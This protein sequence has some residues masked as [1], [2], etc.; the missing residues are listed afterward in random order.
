MATERMSALASSGSETSSEPSTPPSPRS[1]TTSPSDTAGER[2]SAPRPGW[3]RALHRVAASLTLKLVALI[4]IF[5]A[6]PVVLYGQFESADR[7][8]RDLV[9]RALQDRSALIADA[10]AP[11]LK[12]IDPSK[13]QVALNADLAKYSSDGTILKL[14][15]QPAGE[16]DAAGVARRVFFLAAAPPIPAPEV[17]AALARLS[18]PPLLPRPSHRCPLG[19]T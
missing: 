10:L 13:G 7:Q 5:A 1:I 3:R 6:L 4:G 16:H 8:M 15:F 12:N 19:A 2:P 11:T 14:M 17:S 9:T 18:P